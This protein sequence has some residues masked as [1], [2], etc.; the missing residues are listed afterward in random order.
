M[1]V[2]LGTDNQ[3]SVNTQS[4]DHLFIK[5]AV[6]KNCPPLSAA[7]FEHQLFALH[8]MSITKNPAAP[9]SS[10]PRPS[11]AL[12][13]QDSFRGILSQQ[14]ERLVHNTHT[15]TPTKKFKPH[16]SSSCLSATRGCHRHGIKNNEPEAQRGAQTGSHTCFVARSRRRRR[17]FIKKMQD[18]LL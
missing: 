4:Q 3:T 1:T 13:P 5:A 16:C 11:I 12:Q 18:S 2:G 15:H 9:H 14:H 17:M 10:Q 7:L 6:C 8:R